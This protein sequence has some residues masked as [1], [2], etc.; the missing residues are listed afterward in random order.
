MSEETSGRGMNYGLWHAFTACFPGPGT[1][2]LAFLAVTCTTI[3][4]GWTTLKYGTWETFTHEVFTKTKP[5]PGKVFKGY[6]EGGMNIIWTDLIDTEI[7]KSTAALVRVK[8]GVFVS[9][10]T[11][12]WTTGMKLY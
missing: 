6:D 3:N 8:T 5:P 12:S 11:S 1:V 7:I 2:G 9:V 4:S 10:Q